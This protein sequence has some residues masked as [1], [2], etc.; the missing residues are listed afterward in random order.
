MRAID[1]TQYSLQH[2]SVLSPKSSRRI[3]QITDGITANILHILNNVAIDG[4][5]SGIEPITDEAV[6]NWEAQ[7][8]AKATFA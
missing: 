7:F 6:E 5:I 3:L 8:D 1:P 4:I 2:P